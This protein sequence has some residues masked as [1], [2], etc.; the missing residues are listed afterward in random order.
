[1]F[2]HAYDESWRYFEGVLERLPGSL[3]GYAPT[4]RGHGDADRPAYG[5]LPEDF[6][7]D[8]VGF[9]DVL[10]I[11]R[12]VLVG[13]SSGG[14]VYQ[15]VASAYPERVSALALISSP[16]SLGDK[17]AVTAM[18]EETA[19][20]QDPLNAGFVAEFVRGTSPHIGARRVHR[21][22]HPGDSQGARPGLKRHP[23]R[24]AGHQLSH[25]A[26]AD[27]RADAARLW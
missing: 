3:H 9:M 10:G 14:L 2:V 24:I 16:A 18:W 6:A 7:A 22:A 21:H 15:I 11:G 19:T 26:R 17:P 12:A 23:A 4:Q 20:P 1:M 8:L 27:H 13:P 25:E 5:Y